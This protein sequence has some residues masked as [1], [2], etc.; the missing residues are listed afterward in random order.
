MAETYAIHCLSTTLSPL[1][2]MSG[3]EGNEAVLMREPVLTR[4]GVRRIPCLSGNALRHR[5]VREPGA[6]FLVERWGLGGTLTLRQLNFLFHGGALTE[7]TA[8]QDT[9]GWA[10]MHRLFPL[11]R[12][13]GGSLPDA[14]LPGSLIVNRGVLVCRENAPRLRGLV[15]FEVP[16]NLR[17]AEAFVEGYQYT[18]GDAR[19][20]AADLARADDEALSATNL[21]IF[22][23]QSVIAGAAFAHGF[24]A[25]HVGELELGALLLSLSLWRDAGGTVGGQSAR[26]H[27]RLGTLIQCEPAVDAAALMAAY[28][29][30]VDA[31]R[32]EA[33]AWLDKAFD[34]PPEKPVKGGKA[35]KGG[36]G[37]APAED[38]SR[39]L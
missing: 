7:S 27:G 18:R 17:P 13:I 21:M 2:H 1:T 35:K 31:V 26:G 23:G 22:S 3:T 10:T 29:A 25:Q 20:T 32:D 12:L 38:Y 34:P 6:R 9:R 14:I 37:D 8:R 33:V 24:V 36:N 15:P 4:D 19:N 11:L 39:V 5:L 16:G 28:A 30:H